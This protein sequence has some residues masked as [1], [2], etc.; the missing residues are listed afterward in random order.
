MGWWNDTLWQWY[1]MANIQIWLASTL[2]YDHDEWTITL[3]Q[4]FITAAFPLLHVDLGGFHSFESKVVCVYS[5]R[6]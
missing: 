3:G 6:N 5:I 4:Y 2:S 1:I